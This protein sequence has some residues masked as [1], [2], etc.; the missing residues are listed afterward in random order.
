[1]LINRVLLV[2][3]VDHVPHLLSLFLQSRGELVVNVGEQAIQMGLELSIRLLQGFSHLFS[4][5]LYKIIF[6]GLKLIDSVI[7]FTKKRGFYS[8]L[9]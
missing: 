2:V 5:S 8:K 3:L 4:C 9:T 7:N 6:L 1:M